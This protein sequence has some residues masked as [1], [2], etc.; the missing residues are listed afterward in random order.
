MNYHDKE[1]KHIQKSVGNRLKEIREANHL[2][3]GELANKSD[4]HRN[5]IS[6]LENGRQNI[7]LLVL[8]KVTKALHI[9]IKD[10]L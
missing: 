10:L 4:L 8:Y 6:L 1:F 3:Q 5:C 7:T 9:N 2:T